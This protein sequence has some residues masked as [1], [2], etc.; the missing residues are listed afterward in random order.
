MIWRRLQKQREEMLKHWSCG[1][2]NS[3]K[4]STVTET[5]KA[6]KMSLKCQMAAKAVGKNGN[7]RFSVNN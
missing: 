7:F 1:L 5:R 4:L 2:G 6:T 3:A